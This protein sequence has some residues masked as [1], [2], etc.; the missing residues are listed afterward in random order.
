MPYDEDD[1]YEN[2]QWPTFLVL[3]AFRANEYKYKDK[4]VLIEMRLTQSSSRALNS[5]QVDTG[6]VSV[7]GERCDEGNGWRYWVRYWVDIAK[8]ESRRVVA[9]HAI[10]IGFK[11]PYA[12]TTWFA[13]NSNVQVVKQQWF[14]Q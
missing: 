5:G 1:G 7:C 14:F 8:R 6:N 9:K 12:N 13:T 4:K 2:T 3:D 10:E 11:F